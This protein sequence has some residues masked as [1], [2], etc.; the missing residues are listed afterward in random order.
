MDNIEL[1][2][3]QRMMRKTLHH[4]QTDHRVNLSKINYRRTK[5]RLPVEAD[6][7]LSPGH[8]RDSID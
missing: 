7:E 1:S 4:C 8:A 6:A 3:E 2:K 5:S